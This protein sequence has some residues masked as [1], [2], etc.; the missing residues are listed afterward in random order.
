M[1]HF[2]STCKII[3]TGIKDYFK[4]K[5]K[6]IKMVKHLKTFDYDTLEP[7]FRK[8]D[9]FF[10]RKP[11]LLR[12]IIKIEKAIHIKHM[13]KAEKFIGDF[14]IEVQNSNGIIKKLLK[15]NK[16]KDILSSVDILNTNN[17]E[18]KW[19]TGEPYERSRRY[20]Y[21]KQNIY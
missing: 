3:K 14:Y 15:N 17:M 9:R 12:Y 21:E 4:H 18:W 8:I 20:K 19:T 7:N 13:T 10:L 6:N 16:L 5:F 2:F 1:F 11:N